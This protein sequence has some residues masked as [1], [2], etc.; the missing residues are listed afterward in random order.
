MLLYFTLFCLVL[1]LRCYILLYFALFHS[2]L[3]CF[4]LC[5]SHSL[6]FSPPVYFAH[7]LNLSTLFVLYTLYFTLLY[8]IFTSL[9]P[10]LLCIASFLYIT[11]LRFISFRTIA[12]CFPYFSWSSF[13]SGFNLISSRDVARPS[14]PCSTCFVEPRA[15]LLPLIPLCSVSREPGALEKSEPD[16]RRYVIYSAC[17]NETEHRPPFWFYAM[18]FNRRFNVAAPAGRF[19]DQPWKS[20]RREITRREE[21][22]PGTP[23]WRLLSVALSPR[24]LSLI[25]NVFRDLFHDSFRSFVSLSLSY[26][27]FPHFPYLFARDVFSSRLSRFFQVCRFVPISC[28]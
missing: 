12:L 3:L 7:T 18:H 28:K 22:E 19:E 5:F 6:L 24:S 9:Y 2:A 10:R 26:L 1:F 16:W 8:S 21:I 11:S 15:I 17:R 25:L 27:R 14:I 23:Q 4:M 13:R 20:T